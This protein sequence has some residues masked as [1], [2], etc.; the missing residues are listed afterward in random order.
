MTG[1]FPTSGGEPVGTL[2]RF[3]FVEAP[4]PIWLVALD[5]MQFLDVNRAATERFGYS[6]EQY[7]AK[8]LLDFHSEAEV[9]R[10]RDAAGSDDEKSSEL[11]GWNT[12]TAAGQNI[13]TDLSVRFVEIHGRSCALICALDM[14][15]R[16]VLEDRLRQAG[17]ME[18]IGMLAGGIAHDFNNLLTIIS[19]Y[20]QLLL[21]AVSESERSSIEQILKASERAAQLTGQLLAFSRRKEIQPQTLDVNRIVSGMST[22]LR[23]LIGEHIELQLSLSPELGAVH[24][25]P[26]QLDQVLMNLVVN[27]RDAMAQ[28]GK[29]VI[30]TANV[31]L[32]DNYTQRHLG[33]RPGR[34]IMIAVNDT[35]I[36]MDQKTREQVFDPFFTTKDKSKGTGLGLSTVYGVVKQAGGT[37]DLYSEPM[38]GT[39]VK[40]FL[41]RAG[42]VAAIERPI[43]APV[44]S[45]GGRETILI[46]EDEDAVRRLV[47]STL[48][49]RGYRVLVASGG[50]DALHIAHNEEHIDLLVT[51]LVMPQMSGVEVAASICKM[52][53]GIRVLFMSGYT[54]RSLQKTAALPDATEFL[55]KPF[56]PAVLA[57]RIREV[58]DKAEGTGSHALGNGSAT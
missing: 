53:P 18:A 42:E 52:R 12:R 30:E 46:V 19:G 22:M 43:P 17:K 13:E 33:V 54:D 6:R 16:H 56:T 29:V 23:R 26:G 31:D 21:N 20:S 45:A 27:A 4:E 11:R 34:Y 35:G 5:T 40:V 10:L 8:K 37:I 58:L 57:N 36:G 1:Y 49:R 3:L 38:H 14:T 44:E 32:T 25:D 51:D 15:A 47:R 24:A 41:P 55:Q 48:E 28:G 2:E 39:S 50:P 7:L 9:Q